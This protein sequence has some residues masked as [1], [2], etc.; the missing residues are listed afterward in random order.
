MPVGLA[1][2]AGA[3]AGGTGYAGFG[4][5]A[6]QSLALGSSV[7]SGIGSMQQ[8]NSASQ[9]ASYNA[10]I[11]ANNA[12]LQRQN[13]TMISQEGDIKAAQAGAKTKAEAGAML[14]NMGASGVDVGSQ[15][16]ADTRS[17]AAQNGELN[18]I[19]IRSNAARQAYRELSGATS[20]QAQ[21]QLSSYQAKSDITSGEIGA[22][23]T[24]AGQAFNPVTGW[25][26]F[27]GSNSLNPVSLSGNSG[28]TGYGQYSGN[29]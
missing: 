7:M 19:S 8:A 13:A 24:I 20:S 15:S 5:T 16:Y 26:A 1:L 9:A 18:A 4:L 14:A 29:Y 17:S 3:A 21:S 22:A 11:E 23:T 28:Y 10:E 2:A 27:K 25:A 6:M 12:A